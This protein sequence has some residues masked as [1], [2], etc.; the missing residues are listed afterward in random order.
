MYIYWSLNSGYISKFPYSY[1]T[2]T[3]GITVGTIAHGKT[4]WI[5]Q[6]QGRSASLMPKINV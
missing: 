6:N 3:H 4:I 2:T 5:S 1:I